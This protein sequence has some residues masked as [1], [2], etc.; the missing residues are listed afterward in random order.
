M[1]T[2]QDVLKDFEKLGYVVLRNDW[3]KLVLYKYDTVIK[4]D[5]I[6]KWYKKCLAYS[7]GPSKVIII[8]EHKLL[9]E[10][11]KIWGEWI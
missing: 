10:L 2:E 5:K 8:E 3:E 11:F 4:I 1:R 6:E 9:N 7:N